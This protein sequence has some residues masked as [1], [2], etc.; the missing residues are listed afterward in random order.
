MECILQQGEKM[1]AHGVSTRKDLGEQCVRMGPSRSIGLIAYMSTTATESGRA[2]KIA[3]VNRCLRMASAR[4]T[5]RTELKE[6]L[7]TYQEQRSIPSWLKKE[8]K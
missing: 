2:L 8:G 3:S 6:Q 7:M 1:I 5:Y 4:Y